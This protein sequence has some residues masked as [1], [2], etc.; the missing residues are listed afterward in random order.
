LRFLLR[1]RDTK[2][3]AAFDT[4]FT[5]AGMEVTRTPPQAPCTNATMPDSPHARR[6]EGAQELTAGPARYGRS[7]RYR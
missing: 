5:A 4:V 6:S 1:D 2:F 3:G 7:V